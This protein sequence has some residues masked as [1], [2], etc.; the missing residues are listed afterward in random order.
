MQLFS[1]WCW[2]ILTAW[3]CLQRPWWWRGGGGGGAGGQHVVI[4]KL[5]HVNSTKVD[6]TKRG[7]HE[8]SVS[9]FKVMRS[10]M[11]SEGLVHKNVFIL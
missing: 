5:F 9:R 6:T 8:D 11:Y 3:D 4:I 1:Y 10:Q 2:K 7:G